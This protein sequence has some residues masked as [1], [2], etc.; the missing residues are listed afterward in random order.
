[1]NDL[2]IPRTPQDFALLDP[3]PMPPTPDELYRVLDAL[4]FNYELV[5]IFE[6]VRILS[7]RVADEDDQ[8]PDEHQ[9]E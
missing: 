7:F 1:M 6:G 2:H 3:I 8:D 9:E 5:E 4:G